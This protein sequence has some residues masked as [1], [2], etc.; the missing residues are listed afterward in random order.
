MRWMTFQM[1]LDQELV[2]DAK[3]IVAVHPAPFN[4]NEKPLSKLYLQGDHTFT[5]Y[6]TAQNIVTE[7]ANSTRYL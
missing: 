2:V 4:E 6:G 3:Q 5:V 7:I 1:M